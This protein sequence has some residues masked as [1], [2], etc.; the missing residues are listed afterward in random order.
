M[1]HL[2]NAAHSESKALM[3]ASMINFSISLLKSSIS[4]LVV[5]QVSRVTFFFMASNSAFNALT[6]ASL[7][8]SALF[9][10]SV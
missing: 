1:K 4:A 2:A 8:S 7:L 10:A 3:E 6:I 9:V 5:N